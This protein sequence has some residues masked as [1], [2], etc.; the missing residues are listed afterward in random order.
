M[1]ELPK[2]ITQ[3]LWIGIPEHGDEPR[4]T[5]FDMSD[6][7][8]ASLGSV[9]VTVDVPQADLVAKKIEALERQRDKIRAEYSQRID[10]IDDQIKRLQ[11]IEHKPEEKA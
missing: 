8:W 1:K 4:I 9:D 3:T 5:C 6:M 10:R 11:A 2:T 7:G